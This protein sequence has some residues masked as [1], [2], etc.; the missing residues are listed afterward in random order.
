[1]R[2]R[3]KSCEEKKSI[4]FQCVTKDTSGYKKQKNNRGRQPKQCQTKKPN[5]KVKARM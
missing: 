1:M 5:H 2:E 3:K 4:I